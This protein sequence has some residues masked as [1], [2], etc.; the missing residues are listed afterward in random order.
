MVTCN[1]CNQ[2]FLSI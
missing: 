1:G 2:R